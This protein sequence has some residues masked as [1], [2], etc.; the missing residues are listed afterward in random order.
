[1]SNTEMTG[2]ELMKGIVVRIVVAF[3]ALGAVF[4]VPAG[5]FNYW[6]AWL[7]LALLFLGMSLVILYL[8]RNDRALLERRMRFR[9][10]EAVQRRVISLTYVWFA[11]SFVLPGLDHRFGW[12]KMPVAVVL[13]CVVL[14]FAGYFVFFLVLRENSYLS[15]VVE[16]TQGQKVI[17]SGPY[18]LVRHPMYLGV[19][20]MYVFTPLA[21]GS[22][23]ALIPT[24]MIIPLLIMR[25]RNEESVLMR[26]LQGYEDYM[27]KTRYRLIPGL[28]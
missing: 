21:L 25:I 28:W 11:L 5:S 13:A 26:E 2:P 6:E 27:Q 20:V 22:Y 14:T 8:L 16:V 12:S 23:W 19:I 15:R 7:Y 24:V 10:K 3:A 18:A 4:F 9:E 1:M 17:S